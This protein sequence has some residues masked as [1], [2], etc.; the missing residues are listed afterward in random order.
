MRRDSVELT[1]FTCVC[2][3][4]IVGLLLA[5]DLEG[6]TPD[7]HHEYA[8]QGPYAA[9]ALLR[10]TV[11]TAS[12]RGKHTTLVRLGPTWDTAAR[13]DAGVPSNATHYCFAY[14]LGDLTEHASTLLYLDKRREPWLLFLLFGMRCSGLL[15][16]SARLARACSAVLAARVRA[17]TAP[18]AVDCARRRLGVLP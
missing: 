4:N 13:E 16:G 2:N 3:A 14:P 9:V 17:L 6:T 8:V 11:G 5:I 7:G 15:H 10:R 1:S 12:A 18:T